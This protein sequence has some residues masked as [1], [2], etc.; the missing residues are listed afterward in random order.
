MQQRFRR[1]HSRDLNALRAGEIN[2]AA[3]QTRKYFRSSSNA[4][5]SVR[6]LLMFS[7]IASVSRALVLLL[8]AEGGEE[9]PDTSHGLEP[10]QVERGDVW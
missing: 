2:A 5:S 10:G 9:S 4:D 1:V 6:P 7:G 8:R 3:K